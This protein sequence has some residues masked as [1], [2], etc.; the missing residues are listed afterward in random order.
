MADRKRRLLWR[1]VRQILRVQ[2]L[3]F[4]SQQCQNAGAADTFIRFVSEQRHE[5]ILPYSTPA[6]RGWEVAV[7]EQYQCLCMLL[8]VRPQRVVQLPEPHRL[9]GVANGIVAIGDLAKQA[10]GEVILA[11]H[12]L[13]SAA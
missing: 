11:P 7:R 2:D 1:R 5:D 12:P 8:G 9:Q 4:G 3:L 13:H 10:P 6:A